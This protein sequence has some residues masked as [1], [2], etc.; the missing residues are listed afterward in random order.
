MVTVDP[1]YLSVPHE[2]HWKRKWILV[3]RVSELRRKGRRETHGK[4]VDNSLS[5]DESLSGESDG[6]GSSSSSVGEDR[7]ESSLLDDDVDGGGHDDGRLKK[8]KNGIA[9]RQLPAPL[10][11]KLR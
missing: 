10:K 7:D 3:M 9:T 5:L 6:S 4:R 11:T 2:V 1:P 8:R